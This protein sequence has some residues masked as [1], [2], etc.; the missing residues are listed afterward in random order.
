MFQE[1]PANK[2]SVWMRKPI[3]GIGSN[4]ADYLTEYVLDNIRFRCP[5]YQTWLHML[6]RCYS[7]KYQTRQLSYL[8]CTV[9]AEWLLFSNFKAWM[10]LQDW[11]DKQLDKDLI[12]R[13]N[14]IYSPETCIFIS[15]DINALLTS[16]KRNKGDF[17]TGVSLYKPSGKYSAKINM[18]GKRK[19][20]GYYLTE[21]EAY[22]VYKIFKTAHIRAIALEQTDDRLKQSMLQYIVE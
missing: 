11:K 4:D 22:Q 10:I 16:C 20:L 13:G 7:S 17:P 19:H 6:S 8:N 1:I 12:T 3:L 21:D 9:C 18:Y 15:Q 5:Y 2:R 14:K